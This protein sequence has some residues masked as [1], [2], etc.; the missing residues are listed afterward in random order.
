[1]R[2]ISYIFYKNVVVISEFFFIK[3]HVQKLDKNML[4]LIFFHQNPFLGTKFVYFN[5]QLHKKICKDEH[6]WWPSGM[7]W[8]FCRHIINSLRMKRKRDTNYSKYMFGVYRESWNTQVWNFYNFTQLFLRH[9][10]YHYR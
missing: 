6:I 10:I 3:Q 9:D 4:S 1:V 5:P 8:M 7:I 2:G